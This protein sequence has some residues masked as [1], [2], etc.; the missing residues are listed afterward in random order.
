VKG[1]ALHSRGYIL[2]SKPGHPY[3]NRG[4]YVP[5]HRLVVEK[6][7]GRFVNP[8]TE[9]VHHIDQNKKN[10]DPSNLL[11]LD[12]PS[13]SRY[14]RGW[15][16]IDGIWW[17]PCSKC[18]RFL[19]VAENFYR[20]HTKVSEFVAFC[21]DCNKRMSREAN[22]TGKG[23]HTIICPICGKTKYIRSY[24]KTIYCSKQ[25]IWVVRKKGNDKCK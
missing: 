7:I 12:I 18:G 22:K 4:N 1:R 19:P 14:H 5:E 11:L 13:H 3:A 25:C 2:I 8:K 20:R 9:V 23:G 21:K 16:L 6:L 24:R 10:N 17:K 15:K